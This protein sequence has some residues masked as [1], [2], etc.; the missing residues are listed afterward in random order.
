MFVERGPISAEVRR[1]LSY[2]LWRI[3][4]SGTSHPM[5]LCAWKT[6]EEEGRK[7]KGEEISGFL[8]WLCFPAAQWGGNKHP[9]PSAL[10]DRGQVVLLAS[11]VWVLT[12]LS[13]PQY[14]NILENYL[15]DSIKLS[16][17]DQS[18]SRCC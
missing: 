6:L 16:P 3:E 17:E 15:T 11:Q 4:S 5:V 12:S 8:L 9:A 2:P 13:L 14:R 7:E 1:H 10:R 18:R